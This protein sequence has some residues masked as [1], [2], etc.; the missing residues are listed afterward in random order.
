MTRT[1]GLT[2]LLSLSLLLGAAVGA[3]NAGNRGSNGDVE[4]F[5]TAHS[6]HG[7]GSVSGP[8]R[9]ASL[10]LQVLLPSGHWTY[11]R[12]SCSETLRVETIDYQDGR[13]YEFGKNGFTQEC[14]IFGCLDI[15]VGRR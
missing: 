13:L 7:N 15:G 6:R 14:G 10:G 4:G 12:R 8:V 11:C 3:A 2:A 5:V 9:D 1:F